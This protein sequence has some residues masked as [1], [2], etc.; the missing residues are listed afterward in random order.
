MVIEN[1]DIEHT[2]IDYFEIVVTKT[3]SNQRIDRLLSH[4]IEG[5]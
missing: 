5:V 4:V 2:D 1:R 3:Y